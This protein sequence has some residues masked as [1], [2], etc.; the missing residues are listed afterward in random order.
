M[1]TLEQKYLHCSLIFRRASCWPRRSGGTI[2]HDHFHSVCS[3]CDCTTV[4]PSCRVAEKGDAH[5][6]AHHS[7]AFKPN[8][9]KFC[10]QPPAPTRRWLTRIQQWLSEEEERSRRIMAEIIIITIIIIWPEM[11]RQYH[12]VTSGVA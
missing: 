6:R 3:K 12:P 4:S 7:R 2:S 5:T 9:S 11:G 8:T 1:I 10:H